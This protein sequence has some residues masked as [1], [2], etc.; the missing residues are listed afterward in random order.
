V[1]S[2]KTTTTTSRSRS[3]HLTIERREEHRDSFIEMSI[4]G[5]SAAEIAE[6]AL[7][8]TL[9]QEPN[10]LEDQHYGFHDSNG[11]SAG[12]IARRPCSG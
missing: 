10:P 12:A 11:R 6:I 7:R 9:F 3:F 4:N 8:V 2:L 5:R 1:E